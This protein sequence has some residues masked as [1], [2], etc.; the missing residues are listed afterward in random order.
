MG[1]IIKNPV[2]L[3]HY[4]GLSDIFTAL[5]IDDI[6]LINKLYGC[7]NRKAKIINSR[8]GSNPLYL[9]ARPKLFIMKSSYFTGFLLEKYFRFYTELPI[10]FND[11]QSDIKTFEKTVNLI[12]ILLVLDYT[13]LFNDMNYFIKIRNKFP[14]DSKL[15]YL[16]DD[17]F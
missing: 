5:T 9:K 4:H 14:E 2:V 8:D 11:P 16:H 1:K 12:K 17:S 15:Y 6:K 7:P 13:I 3:Y 10:D